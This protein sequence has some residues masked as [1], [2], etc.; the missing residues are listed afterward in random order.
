MTAL[1]KY[2]LLLNLYCCLIWDIYFFYDFKMFWTK[3]V[4]TEE[5]VAL[6]EGKMRYLLP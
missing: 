4:L 3:V 5:N 1:L 6:P 2:S